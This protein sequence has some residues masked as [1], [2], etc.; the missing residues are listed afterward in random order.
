MYFSAKIK[1]VF[2]EWVLYSI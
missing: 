1:T 2:W